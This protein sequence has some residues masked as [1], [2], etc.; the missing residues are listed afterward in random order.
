MSE[1]V[2]LGPFTQAYG[3]T[4]LHRVEDYEHHCWH[5][6]SMRNSINIRKDMGYKASKGAL[7]V[8]IGA[9]SVIA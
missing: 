7:R 6:D 1:G 8:D 2:P 5:H 3:I 9:S 4:Q